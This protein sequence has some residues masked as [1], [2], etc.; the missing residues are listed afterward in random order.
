MRH[1]FR[2]GWISLLLWLPLA[3]AA[4]IQVAPTQVYLTQNQPV[5]TLQLTN[6]ADTPVVFQ[7]E[8]KSW[9]Q[10]LGKD[11]LKPTS[12]LIVVPPVIKLAAHDKQLVRI[13]LQAP[14]AE[15]K[16]YRLLL[17]EIPQRKKVANTINT[18]LQIRLPVFVNESEQPELS[19]SMLPKNGKQA[20]LQLANKG[21][22]HIQ[23]THLMLKDTQTGKIYWQQTLFD[24]IL[25]G[26]RMQWPVPALPTNK[27]WQL[28][29]E[30]DS[31]K[32]SQAM[33]T[34]HA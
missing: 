12:A 14:D 6:A 11:E 20:T 25:P 3:Q 8:A 19:W 26:G 32:L 7:L 16:A 5:A 34:V 10:R 28:I 23:I 22:R 17:Q 18:L 29:A 2:C 24:Y 15:V 9:Q 21:Q 4:A 30:T 13:G 27:K 1:L 33:T 31:G